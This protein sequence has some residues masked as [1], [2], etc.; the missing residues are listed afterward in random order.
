MRKLFAILLFLHF[1]IHLI[2]F[3]KAMGLDFSLDEH[4]IP[5]ESAWLWLLVVL[6]S[7]LAGIFFLLRK[8]VWIILAIPVVIASQVLIILNWEL[9]AFGSW[10]NLIILLVAFFSIAGWKFENTYRKARIRAIRTHQTK[11]RLLTPEDIAHLPGLV[12]DYI[13]RCGFIGRPKIEMLSIRFTGE[14]REHGKNWFPFRSQQFNTI[15]PPSRHFFMKAIYMGI[16]TKGYHCYTGKL[17]SM[18]I[19]ALSLI[20]V[21]SLKTEELLVSEMVTYLNDICL[22][23]PAALI[24]EEFELEQTGKNS[25]QVVFSHEARSVSAMLK[26]DASGRLLDFFSNDR[27]DINTHKKCMF[28]TPVGAYKD[29]NGYHLAS[30]GEATWHLPEDDFVYGKFNVEK[31][32]FNPNT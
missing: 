12:Q 6:L 30:Y 21:V 23:A 5:R 4:R 29:F 3:G 26:F 9:A 15:Y 31:I 2:G 17:A 7:L 28:S 19:K 18:S 25:V 22:F 16:P 20:K 27:Y 14:M 11:P 24:A 13:T 1:L 10:I 32:E 8:P